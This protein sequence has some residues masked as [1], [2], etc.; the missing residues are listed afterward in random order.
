[1]V[2]S[3]KAALISVCRFNLRICDY[4]TKDQKRQSLIFLPTPAIYAS[5]YI[6][7]LAVFFLAVF[8]F[9]VFFFGQPFCMSL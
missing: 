7:F 6:F 8:F 2:R 5:A 4:T 1:M 3:D 9:A